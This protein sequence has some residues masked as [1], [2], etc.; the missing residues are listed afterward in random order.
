MGIFSRI[1]AW[2]TRRQ[3]EA[4]RNWLRTSRVTFV[5]HDYSAA[6]ERALEQLGERYLCKNPINRRRK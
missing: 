4:H 6:R 3:I 2:H 5:P 1:G